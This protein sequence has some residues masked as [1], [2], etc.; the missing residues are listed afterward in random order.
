[1]AKTKKIKL[2]VALKLKE[3][4]EKEISNIYYSIKNFRDSDI[5]LEPLFDEAEYYENELIKLKELLRDANA[6]KHKDGHSND[7]YIYKLSNLNNKLYHLRKVRIDDTDNKRIENITKQVASIKKKLTSF[8]ESTKV[9][10]DVT[11]E[12]IAKL[13]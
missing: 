11:D 5:N 12:R 13:L 2:A 7:Y 3:F 1:M 4:V 10:I 9:T 8:N 6:G